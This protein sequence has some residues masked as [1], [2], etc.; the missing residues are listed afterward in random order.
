MKVLFVFGS[1]VSLEVFAES[2]TLTESSKNFED[3]EI[4]VAIR[5]NHFTKSPD[6]A[7][8]RDA[9]ANV[10]Q[11]TTVKAQEKLFKLM[12]SFEFIKRSKESVAFSRTL[13]RKFKGNYQT[14]F[15]GR[16][17]YLEY[18]KTTLLNPENFVL[19]LG[20]VPILSGIIRKSLRSF[21]P[22]PRQLDA[23]CKELLPD[24]IVL[25]SN[26]AEPSLFEVPKVASNNKVPWNLVVDNWDNLSSKTVF[27]D[28]PD[29]IYVWGNHHSEFAKKFHGIPQ[30]RITEIGTPRLT[31]PTSLENREPK[32]KIVL[33][34]GMQPSY[35]EVSDLENLIHECRINNYELLYRPHPLRKF[36]A[37]EKSRIQEMAKS[38]HFYL[39]FSENFKDY[40]NNVLASLS[41]ST[42]YLRLKKDELLSKN[43]LCVIATPTS[44][45]LEALVY[46]Q[47]LIMVARDDK[48]HKTT[49]ATY[50]NFYPY[51]EPLKSN[52][53]IRVA[54]NDFEML[55]ELRAVA[56]CEHVRS[57]LRIAV[58][59]ICKSGKETWALNLLNEIKLESIELT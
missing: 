47:E 4:C 59:E 42:K 54:T 37:S 27:W 56:A 20:Y 36:T 52:K 33:Y 24:L 38:G 15:L 55:R 53:G 29:H 11:F 34:A 6:K 39:N 51:F 30:N 12:L 13:N 48:I 32:S 17:R 44:L 14:E 19:A 3:I 58:N 5:K 10:Y 41:M 45:A 28:K 1:S 18:L 23:L 40:R 7:Q 50:W 9:S 31:F 35:D 43:L 2:G 22:Y 16:K 8:I 57:D 25:I 26:G 49:A 46:Q 21:Y